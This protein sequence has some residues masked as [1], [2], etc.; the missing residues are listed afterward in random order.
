MAT[1]SWDG[2]Y[3]NSTRLTN[4]GEVVPIDPALMPYDV[5]EALYSA[6]TLEVS[7]EDAAKIVAK[8]GPRDKN[9]SVLFDDFDDYEEEY[10]DED[11][12]EAMF[13]NRAD[14]ADILIALIH[15]S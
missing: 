1:L 12:E 13:Y 4:G 2:N 6:K 8:A 10:T 14:A 3:Y 15:G 7:D 5:W 9:A 11:Y